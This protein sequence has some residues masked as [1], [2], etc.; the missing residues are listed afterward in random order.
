MT[1]AA[2]S[3]LHVNIK[4]FNHDIEIVCSTFERVRDKIVSYKLLD[5]RAS[6]VE[7][8]NISRQR[9]L[10]DQMK[11]TCNASFNILLFSF[12]L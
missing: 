3:K 8:E 12:C 7:S 6:P 11:I 5:K 2:L 1:H 10:S 4:L 9:F